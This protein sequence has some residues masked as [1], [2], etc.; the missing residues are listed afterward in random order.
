MSTVFAIPARQTE[1]SAYAWGA[2]TLD[3]F[4]LSRKF[5]T[6]IF[7]Y[8]CV[9]IIS[10]MAAGALGAYLMLIP[11]VVS[12]F[13]FAP[14][15]PMKALMCFTVYI[16]MEGMYRYLTRFSSFSYVIAPLLAISLV[17]SFVVNGKL[18][19]K[20]IK[21]IKSIEFYAMGLIIGYL[22]IFNPKGAGLFEGTA[23]FLVWYLCP[24]LMYP[25]ACLMKKKEGDFVLFLLVLVA[26]SLV[27]SLV[28]I[29]QH[30][31]GQEWQTRYF[32]GSDSAGMLNT[33]VIM[34]NGAI[35]H[36][37]R[38]ISTGTLGGTYSILSSLG[39]LPLVMMLSSERIPLKLKIFSVIV[40][41]IN[42]YA[43]FISSVR[44][45]VLISVGQSLVFLVL[46]VKDYKSLFRISLILLVALG[47][48]RLSSAVAGAVTDGTS[49]ARFGKTLENPFEAYETQRAY[50]LAEIVPMAVTNPLGI[51]YQRG[52]KGGVSLDMKTDR[53]TQFTSL[54]ADWGLLGFL[55]M[56]ALNVSLLVFMFK[57]MRK[58]NYAARKSLLLVFSWVLSIFA[59]W[60]AGPMIQSNYIMWIYIGIGIML[61]SH[62]KHPGDVKGLC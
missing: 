18:S 35:G 61:C 43:M 32:P 10:T 47:I 15:H 13:N 3:N 54:L 23:T 20:G 19:I 17:I 38:P 27:V 34:D 33:H 26:A 39:V 4:T 52:T 60:F 41:S 16:F 2:I 50:H 55:V 53:E 44:L 62:L 40:L 51:G 9:V 1:E 30:S 56:T 57:R 8:M 45:S 46:G 11:L 22:E 7:L 12:M 6:G 59:A 14:R 31:F 21:N 58:V 49:E 36:S 37:F 28:A 24:M 29:M 25:V 48:L 42:L 5:A